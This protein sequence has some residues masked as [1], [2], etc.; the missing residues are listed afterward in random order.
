MSIC[1]WSTMAS[2]KSGC[3]TWWLV[4]IQ[5]AT[6]S[7]LRSW[8]ASFKL[9]ERRQKIQAPNQPERDNPQPNT[10]MKTFSVTDGTVTKLIEAN[11]AAEA[12]EIG[13][14]IPGT[15]KVTEVAK[16]KTYDLVIDEISSV[17]GEYPGSVD[18]SFHRVIDGERDGFESKR[19]ALT[20]AVV[21][22]D[23]SIDDDEVARQVS[24]AIGQTETVEV[25]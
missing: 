21:K 22:A 5:P 3:G 20:S 23:G 11:S 10:D 4:I 8:R 25:E 24:A 16:T 13:E 12:L 19:V 14:I 7:R 1:A 9:P 15:M 6:A 17:F 2:V 18:V